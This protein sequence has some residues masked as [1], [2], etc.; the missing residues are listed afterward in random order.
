V[1]KTCPTKKIKTQKKEK[2]IMKKNEIKRTIEQVV[3]V[4][5]I[6][7]DGQVFYNEEE[8]K[9]YEQS[10]L[11]AVSSK[12][13]KLNN[14]KFTGI[15][16]LIENGCE[17][18]ELEIFDV[19]TEN[20]LDNLKRYLY[21]KAASHGASD[22]NIK[23]CF[24]SETGTRKNFVFDGVTIGHEV[25]IFWSYEQDWFWVYKDGSLD[26]YFSW[27]RDKY[28]KLIVSEEN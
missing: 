1:G 16:D 27:I 15:Y 3:R 23:E 9:K 14:K 26:G 19:Q 20:D 22:N 13:K 18:D 12:L 11:F 25:L 2:L 10:A 6:A 21:L 28:N 5:Y 4:E 24:T 7:E 8:C 17:E